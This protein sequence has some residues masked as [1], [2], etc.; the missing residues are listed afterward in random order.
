MPFKS[1][2]T[3]FSPLGIAI[4]EGQNEIARLLVKAQIDLESGFGL[5]G[6]ALHL[7]ISQF[8]SELVDLILKQKVNPNL[9]NDSN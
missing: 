6:S 5:F 8:N 4:L 9:K 3:D 2:F 7:A 1:E